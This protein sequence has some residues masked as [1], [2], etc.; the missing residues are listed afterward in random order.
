MTWCWSHKWKVVRIDKYKIV[1][2]LPGSWGVSDSLLDAT[3]PPKFGGTNVKLICRKCAKIKNIQYPGECL[4]K[5]DFA[6]TKIGRMLE[7]R[8]EQDDAQGI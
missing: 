4:T 8:E 3:Y 1:T 5:E 6:G 2:R 7:V